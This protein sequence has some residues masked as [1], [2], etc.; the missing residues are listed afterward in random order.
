MERNVNSRNQACSV[1]KPG[2][3][4]S[5]IHPVTA[6]YQS[7]LGCAVCA[8]CGTINLPSDRREGNTIRRSVPEACA[9]CG[10]NLRKEEAR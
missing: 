8:K 2:N 10:E 9:G 4:R 1:G 6:A 5:G 3:S 7:P